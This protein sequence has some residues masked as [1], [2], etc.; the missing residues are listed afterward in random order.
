MS[1]TS[2]QRPAKYASF[3][4]SGPG[5]AAA[6]A[7]PRRDGET[8][9]ATIASE[10]G[11]ILIPVSWVERPQSYAHGCS[12]AT[13]RSVQRRVRR[14]RIDP[15]LRQAILRIELRPLGIEH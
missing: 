12:F 15:P 13:D 6:G 1:A 3:W 2:F 9:S 7:C 5:L 11:A 4:C 14:R 10:A 8:R